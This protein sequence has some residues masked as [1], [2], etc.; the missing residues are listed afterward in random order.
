MSVAKNDSTISTPTVSKAPDWI[1]DLCALLDHQ[2]RLQ[3]HL[4]NRD[5]LEH[6]TRA[7][8]A[9]IDAVTRRKSV[10]QRIAQDMNVLQ[11]QKDDLEQQ[12]DALQQQI[13]ALRQ[14]SNVLQQQWDDLRQQKNDLRQQIGRPT[15][16]PETL[17][18]GLTLQGLNAKLAKLDKP[19][20][21]LRV[22]EEAL[23]V[24]KESVLAEVRERTAEYKRLRTQT[25]DSQAAVERDE[26]AR[27][28]AIDALKKSGVLDD[29]SEQPY[30]EAERIWLKLQDKDFI[31]C[32]DGLLDG[33][34]MIL[35]SLFIPT[36]PVAAV[37]AAA[38]VDDASG[39]V[40]QLY[41]WE[42]NRLLTLAK[43]AGGAA[44]TVL[45]GLIA[46][47]FAGKTGVNSVTLFVAAPLVAILLFWAGFL[48]AGLRSLADQYPIACELVER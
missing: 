33:T 17:V 10:E 9:M 31:A 24:E 19:S 37:L 34:W 3:R 35:Q 43:G 14:Q 4:L 45:A 25:K 16:S 39:A 12:K 29:E 7:R 30:Y 26:T 47:G 42:R 8:D 1:D 48:L 2:R 13:N 18:I 21:S 5:Q 40:L 6:L 44:V 28:A 27:A 41:E 15:T 38:T 32:S 23:R 46:T 22:R 36:V 20:E 11:Q